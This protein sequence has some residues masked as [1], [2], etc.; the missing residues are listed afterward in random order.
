[1]PYARKRVHLESP[2]YT[3][4]SKTSRTVAQHT[5]RKRPSR[6]TP[7]PL[8][9]NVQQRQKKRPV[10][11]KR[12]KSA[13]KL[14]K[15]EYSQSAPL[16]LWITISCAFLAFIFTLGVTVGE[17]VGNENFN[18]EYAVLTALRES[19]NEL[20]RR[21]QEVNLS[22]IDKL[23]RERYGMHEPLESQIVKVDMPSQSYVVH[24]NEETEQETVSVTD[25]IS[26]FFGLTKAGE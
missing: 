4:Y 2:T 3:S 21:N 25:F 17:I 10:R 1:M 24:Y 13:P 6:E 5:E 20:Q 19:N 14:R 8:S 11:A 18:K 15:I 22:E 16:T 12:P 26:M 7:P 9:R 23:A